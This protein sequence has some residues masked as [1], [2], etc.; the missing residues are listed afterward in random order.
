MD[1][2]TADDPRTYRWR[3]DDA[4]FDEARL[5]LQVGGRAAEI[6]QKPLQVLA[7]LLRHAG[8]V[9]TKRELFDTVW[10]GRVTVDHVLATAVGKLRKALGENGQRLIVTVPRIGYR[11]DGHVERVAVGRRPTASPQFAASQPVPGR[12]HFLLER[13]LG[14]SQLNEVWL[15]RHPKTRQPRVFKFGADGTQLSALKREATVSRM[16]VE[17]LPGH[18]DFARVLDWNFE[19]APFFLECEYGG[20]DL[21]EWAA[22]RPDFANWPL[23]RRLDLFLQLADAVAAAHGVGILHKDIKPA[24]VLIADGG[25][26]PRVRLADFGSSRLLEP[27]R[28]AELGITAPGLSATQTAGADSSGGTPL[29]LAPE[30]IAGQPPTVRSDVYAL[31]IL[32][33]QFAVGDFRKPLASGWERDIDDALLRETSHTPPTASRHIDRPAPRSW[34]SACARSRCG[35]PNAR[36]GSTKPTARR[37]CKAGSNG[38]ARAGRGW[39]RWPPVSCSGSACGCTRAPNTHAAARSRKPRAPRRSPAFST[40]TSS[41]APT[42]AGSALKRIRR[43]ANCSTRRRTGSAS[44]STRRRARAPPCSRRSVTPIPVSAPATAARRICAKPRRCGRA[45]S[46]NAIRAPC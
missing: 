40:T 42:P 12:P 18:E 15:A 37:R 25:D 6:E 5:R 32:L 28:L 46:A 31:G 41:A 27:A 2:T 35:V 44:A 21:P 23:Q 39:P 43:F 7:L 8:E 4:E 14:A 17:S 29:Y 30:L 34:P 20:P 45:P 16:L 36:S 3:F 24:N 33:Y 10:A 26:R 22:A 19:A 38:C 1:E 13:R 11:L 9:V